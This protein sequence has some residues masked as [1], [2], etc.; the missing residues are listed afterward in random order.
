MLLSKDMIVIDE[1]KCPIIMQGFV[2]SYVLSEKE[3]AAGKELPDENS[4]HAHA[5][6]CL[7][8]GAVNNF[9]FEEDPPVPKEENKIIDAWFD[10]DEDEDG[11]ELGGD[12]ELIAVGE[13]DNGY[14]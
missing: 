2:K 6:A 14:Y 3:K 13:G 4:Y 11:D 8:Y 7:R 9:T 12:T 1:Q 5:Q 10:E